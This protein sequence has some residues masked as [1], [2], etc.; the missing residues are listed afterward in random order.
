MAEAQGDL[1]LLETDVA[2]AL[3][4]SALPARVA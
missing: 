3:L 1:S 2:L 4:A